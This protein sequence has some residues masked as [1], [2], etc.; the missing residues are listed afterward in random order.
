MALIQTIKQHALLS[1]FA[2]TF[3]LTWLCWITLDILLPDSFQSFMSLSGTSHL[4]ALILLFLL[5]DIVPS[6]IGITLTRIVGS[7]GSLRP[8]FG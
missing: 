7:K 5:G 2:L 3:A 4:S 8:L 6:S 1:Y